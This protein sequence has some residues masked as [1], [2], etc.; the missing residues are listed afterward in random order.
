MKPRLITKDEWFAIRTGR[1]QAM[2]GQHPHRTELVPI[3]PKDPTF[4]RGA[5]K[6]YYWCMGQ[7]PDKETI[8]RIARRCPVKAAEAY[9]RVYEFNRRT[10]WESASFTKP[11]PI[12]EK[13]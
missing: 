7:Q 1:G 6:T 9:L 2:T 5:G 11:V 4:V 8:E 10:K 12:K 3:D 13:T